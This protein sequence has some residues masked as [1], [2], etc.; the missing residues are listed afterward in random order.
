[1]GKAERNRRENARAKIAAQQAAARRAERRRQAL[2]AGG[3]VLVVLAIVVVFI[4]IK[5]VQSPTTA[6]GTDVAGAKAIPAVAQQVTSVPASTLDAVGKGGASALSPVS[7]APAL[8]ANGKPEMVYMGAEY[9]PFCAG[10]RWA[11]VVALSRFG[12]FSNLHFIHSSSTD[13]DPSTPT[14]TF[15]RSSYSS[16]YLAFDPVELY[17]SKPESGSRAGYTTLQTPTQAESA[18]MSKYDAAPYVPSADAG[19]FPFVDIGNKYLV[20]GG[21]FQPSSLAG[22]TWSQVATD[23]KDPSSPVAKDV[24]GAANTITAAICKITNDKPANVCSS[25]G[26]QA[27]AGAL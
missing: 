17:T 21:Q 25:A 13:T 9:C 6:A 27:G 14:L 1:M 3:S 15:Y 11:M 20:I 10:E 4:V 26:A 16:K 23:I 19:S 8:T 5:V 24:D 18:L 22:L 12:T 7:G 2:I